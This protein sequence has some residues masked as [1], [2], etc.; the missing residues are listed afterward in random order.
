M[1]TKFNSCRVLNENLSFDSNYAPA[2]FQPFQP[3]VKDI[4]YAYLPTE[5]GN[6]YCDDKNIILENNIVE[7]SYDS[8]DDFCWKPLRVR[9]T[10]KPNDFVT[11]TN[12]W[13]SIHNPVTQKMITSGNVNV[14]D[15][16]YYTLNKKRQN[17]ESKS[18]YDFHSYVKKQLI[19][20]NT[21]G[22][23]NILDLGVGK[24][25]DL[26]HV[27]DAKCNILVGIDD[28]FDNLSNSEN[29]MCN[30]I[31]NKSTDNK[32]TSIL[33]N[34]LVI[35]A[36]VQK[37]ILNGVAGN[38]ELNKYYLDVIY[39]NITLDKINNSKLRQFYN[40]GNVAS[41]FGF[42]L[43]SVQFAMHYFFKDTIMLN[44][45]LN[46]VS[47]SLKSGGRFIGTC[48]DGK[49]VF[50]ELRYTN[51]IGTPKLWTIKKLYESTS[52]QDNDSSLGYEIEVF[53][54]SIGASIKEYLVNF[55]YLTEKAKE[56]NLQLVELN[57]FSKIFESSDKKQ[58][59][60]MKEMTTELKEYSF[61]NNAFVFEKI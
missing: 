5:N 11:A 60:S 2:I 17:R 37:D 45:F 4:H 28:I 12:V 24:G 56:Y 43:V 16:I 32:E 51:N 29:G 42:D 27:I 49:K 39:G 57:N 48:F 50:N 35:W 15:N 44:N 34:T 36:N 53:N 33:S 59:G 9:D 13:G 25:G 38:D 26:N 6:I 23:R 14:S 40:I 1:H 18:M 41:G 21:L 55:D 20:D 47:K 54:E 46:N 3:Y 22:E 30:R 7:F 52:F 19:V 10:L 58:Y 61:F 31:L 8:N